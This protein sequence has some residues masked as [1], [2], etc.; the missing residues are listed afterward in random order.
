MCIYA[1]KNNVK[2]V[3]NFSS[4][5]SSGFLEKRS[6]WVD[7]KI[8]EKFLSVVNLYFPEGTPNIDFL[9]SLKP[10]VILSF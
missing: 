10:S 3:G 6:Q 8:S 1:T 4:R 7:Y 2:W 5:A 9:D